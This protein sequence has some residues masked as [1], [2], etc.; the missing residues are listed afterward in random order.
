M[1]CSKLARMKINMVIVES[2]W[3]GHRNWWY[4][5]EGKNLEQAQEFIKTAQMYNL[6][7]VPLVQGGGWAYGVAD[8]NPFLCEGVWVKDEQT[9]V[10]GEY[11]VLKHPNVLHSESQPII[12]RSQDASVTYT[13]GKDYEVVRGVTVRRFEENHAPWKLKIL[14]DGRLKPGTK[15]SLDYNYVPFSPHQSPYC[16]S[17]PATYKLLHSVLSN[18]VKI[19][20]PRFIHI[21]H[22]E[23]IRRNTD[24]RCIRRGL[25]RATLAAE[26]LNWWYKT[27]KTLDPTITIM[28]WDDM[29]R[30]SD[31]NGRLLSMLPDDIIICPWHYHATNDARKVIAD[32]VQWFIGERHRPTIGT[33][34]GYFPMN[35]V[36]GNEELAKYEGA[37]E[38]L[39]MMFTHWGESIWLW[40]S[41]PY[42]AD[43]MW[44][45]SRPNS[46]QM[47][48]LIS[49][50]ESLRQ[51]ALR[52]SLD[53]P[54]QMNSFANSI[55]A[56]D[57][58]LDALKNALAKAETRILADRMPG[59]GGTDNPIFESI[60]GQG[61]RIVKYYE[62]MRLAR[63]LPL[64]KDANSA[65]RYFTLLKELMPERSDEWTKALA[66][67]LGNGSLPDTKSVFGVEILP[68]IDLD[69][70]CL[71]CKAIP[72]SSTNNNNG[73]L[74][75]LCVEQN[76]YM[77]QLK[78]ASPGEY[79]I[80]GG[81][82]LMPSPRLPLS[83]LMQKAT[84][85]PVSSHKK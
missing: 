75:E 7:V 65:R 15:L 9:E 24:R 32:R 1:I 54:L 82:R 38:N 83:W 11:V 70:A 17:D 47:R 36:I 52:P 4:R 10:S 23:V 80:S 27:L 28:I 67:Y 63:R 45:S 62:A 68:G 69:D 33:A 12:V 71:S 64:T 49:C 13:E 37:K 57:N 40:S 73:R 25:D 44:S 5:P 2:H 30:K 34:S 59:F 79:A 41:L 53:V 26:D 22:D 61:R 29:V 50:D 74:I 84:P 20:H 81:L 77:V 60:I 18:M 85:K 8:R 58:K 19:Y 48:L 3:N 31:E 42:T 43:C 6:E 56:G 55:N 21:G 35:T 16:P 78:G 66:A 76:L 14:P 39:G 51:F 72:F 46:N